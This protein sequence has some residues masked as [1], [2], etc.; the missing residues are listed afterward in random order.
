MGSTNEK[1]KPVHAIIETPRGRRHKYALDDEFGIFKLRSI[2]AE[3]LSWPFDYGLF[4]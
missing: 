2:I 1:C 4:P 3:G